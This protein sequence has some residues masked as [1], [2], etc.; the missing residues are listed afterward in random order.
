MKLHSR[1]SRAPAGLTL[2]ELLVIVF[3]I[4]LALAFLIPT[5][6]SA[7][8]G[9]SSNRVKCASNLRQIGQA[10]QLYCNENHGNFPRTVY[11]PAPVVVPACLL[12]Q[13]VAAGRRASSSICPEH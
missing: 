10:I 9:G 3:V 13:T 12:S 5:M 11:T 2:V 8:R 1:R 4:F 6:N 7:N